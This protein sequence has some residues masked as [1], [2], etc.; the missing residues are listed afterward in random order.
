MQAAKE[1]SGD[2]RLTGAMVEACP[3]KASSLTQEI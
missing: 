3:D 1:N 2:Y